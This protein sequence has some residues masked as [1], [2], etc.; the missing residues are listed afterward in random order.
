MQDLLPR[1]L[2]GIITQLRDAIVLEQLER[3]NVA[4]FKAVMNIASF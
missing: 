2:D 4:R 1:Y 3:R